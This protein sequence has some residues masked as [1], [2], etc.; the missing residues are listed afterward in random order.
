MPWGGGLF[1]A[2]LGGGELIT[3]TSAVFVN[4]PCSISLFL[5]ESDSSFFTFSELSDCSSTGAT[6]FSLVVSSV[7]WDG[8]L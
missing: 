2:L 8:V 6:S 4:S 5:C 3:I 7:F 1:V